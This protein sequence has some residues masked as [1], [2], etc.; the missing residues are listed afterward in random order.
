VAKTFT[1]PLPTLEAS[2]S[3]LTANF[4]TPLIPAVT[5]ILFPPVIQGPLYAAGL[6]LKRVF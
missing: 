2:I 1:R 4:F 5:A 3:S 6:I